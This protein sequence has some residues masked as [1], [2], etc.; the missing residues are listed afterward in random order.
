[1]SARPG[2]ERL[3]AGRLGIV[4]FVHE[5]KKI[6]VS[7]ERERVDPPFVRINQIHRPRHYN[8]FSPNWRG[9]KDNKF[10]GMPTMHLLAY[11]Q[12]AKHVSYSAAAANDDGSLAAPSALEDQPDDKRCPSTSPKLQTKKPTPHRSGRRTQRTWQD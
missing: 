4:T 12:R 6:D 5:T 2:C 10:S 9:D 11:W 8:D 7:W 3:L 1:M